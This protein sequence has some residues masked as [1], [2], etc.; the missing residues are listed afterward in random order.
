MENRPE[1]T[2]GG[3]D[4]PRWLSSC[5]LHGVHG[6]MLLLARQEPKRSAIPD[7]ARAAAAP[8]TV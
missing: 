1:I 5:V 8:T 3:G 6:I 2:P 4:D 7:L